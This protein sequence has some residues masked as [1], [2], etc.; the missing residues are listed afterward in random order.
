MALKSIALSNAQSK[1]NAAVAIA[2]TQWPRSKVKPPNLCEIIDQAWEILKNV[3]KHLFH[4][5]PSHVTSLEC[6][7]NCVNLSRTNPIVRCVQRLKR[8]S[9]DRP[10]RVVAVCV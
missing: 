5:H 8:T 4:M 9:D 7:E 3:V 10:I 1:G 6:G 2:I